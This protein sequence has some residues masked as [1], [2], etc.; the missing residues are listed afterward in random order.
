VLAFQMDKTRIVHLHVEQ[1]P[2]ADELQVHRGRPRRAAPRPDARQTPAT[3]A[4]Y[5][6]TNQFHMK[7]FT[8]LVSRLKQIDEGGQS[9]LDNSLLMFASSLYDGDLHG[10]DQM[11]R[12]ARRQG[13]R[14]DEARPH[15]DFLDKGN[16]KSPRLQPLPFDDGPHGRKVGRSRYHNACPG[17]SLSYSILPVHSA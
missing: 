5:L 17:C 3:K 1:R 2:L 15:F 11:A 8:Y 9:L 14:R 16:D 12:G 13:G 10:A 7:Q 6:K 4:M